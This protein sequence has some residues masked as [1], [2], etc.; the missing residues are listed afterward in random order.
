[1]SIVNGFE[2]TKKD[3]KDELSSQA[4]KIDQCLANQKT[5]ESQMMDKM[6]VRSKTFGDATEPLNEV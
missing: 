5:F 4:A 3:L 6:N 2:A 1:M